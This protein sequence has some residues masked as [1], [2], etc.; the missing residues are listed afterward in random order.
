M[1]KVKTTP[2]EVGLEDTYRWYARNHKPRTGFDL[3]DKLLA[4]SRSGAVAEV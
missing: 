4:M 3:D 1:L 2:F